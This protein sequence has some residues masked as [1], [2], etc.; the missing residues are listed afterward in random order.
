MPIDTRRLIYEYFL[1]FWTTC[2]TISSF[3]NSISKCLFKKSVQ[4]TE[5]CSR[6]WDT[7]LIKDLSSLFPTGGGRTR[8]YQ[9][10]R[11]CPKNFGKNKDSSIKEKLSR[12]K[13]NTNKIIKIRIQLEIIVECQLTFC[14]FFFF[15]STQD[16]ILFIVRC[17]KLDSHNNQD[18]EYEKNNPKNP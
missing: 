9:R 4:T 14:N 13:M 12:K 5:P 17:P 7:F 10:G 16:C 18:Q 6:I 15:R 3:N 1:C 8:A 11:I 2:L